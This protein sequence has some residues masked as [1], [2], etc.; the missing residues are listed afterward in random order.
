[1][2][3]KQF[4]SLVLTLSPSWARRSPQPHQLWPV[5]PKEDVSTAEKVTAVLALVLILKI[6]RKLPKT[7]E[8][9]RQLILVST[10]RDIMR[11]S[12]KSSVI[13]VQDCPAVNLVKLW[14]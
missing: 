1:M 11:M 12:H 3:L 2:I 5:N 7:D 9:F 10:V 13:L 6:Q 4:P 8:S 14:V